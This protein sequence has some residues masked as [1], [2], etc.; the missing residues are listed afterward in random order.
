M[1]DPV[2]EKIKQTQN[3][4]PPHAPSAVESCPY[5]KTVAEAEPSPV[6]VKTA[7]GLT[8]YGASPPLPT[9]TPEKAKTKKDWIEIILVDMEGKPV[10]NVR[11]RIT[12]P[13]GAVKEGT[14]NEHGQAGFY[15]IEAGNCKVTFPDLD[16]EAW[17]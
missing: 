5:A 2:A 6:T 12:A 11:Y 13:D 17:D 4:F 1:P 8:Q 16:K 15:Q 9:T 14:L 7:F 10:P 3:A